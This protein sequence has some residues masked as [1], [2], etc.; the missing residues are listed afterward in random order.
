MH[1]FW[2][3]IQLGLPLK[4]NANSQGVWSEQKTYEMFAAI[5]EYTISFHLIAAIL[6]L[7]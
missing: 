5:A 7:L 4:T 1:V 3:I 6:N 2:F